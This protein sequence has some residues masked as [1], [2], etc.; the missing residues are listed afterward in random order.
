M[1][2]VRK[3]R[4]E[5]KGKLVLPLDR[6]RFKGELFDDERPEKYELSREFEIENPMKTPPNN[7][8]VKNPE[9]KEKE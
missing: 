7:L 9:K 3:K 1:G 2:S 6:R 5:S 4:E 8:T